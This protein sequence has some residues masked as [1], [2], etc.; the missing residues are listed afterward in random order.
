MI[1]AEAKSRLCPSSASPPNYLPLLSRWSGSKNKKEIGRGHG[2]TTLISEVYPT[3]CSW[4]S[5][6]TAQ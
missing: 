1:R 3:S 2:L 6:R 4:R 5:T